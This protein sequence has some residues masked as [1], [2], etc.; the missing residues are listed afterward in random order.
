MGLK[1]TVPSLDDVQA[2]HQSLYV[3]RGDGFVLDVEG[4]D[5]H[6]EVVNLKTAY[7]RVKQD[8][9]AI[10]TER[11][12]AK[13][14]MSGL[15]ADFDAEVWNRA[16][17]GKADPAELVQLRQTLEADRDQ[18]KAKAEA[19]DKQVYE[20]TVERN[21][22]GLLATAGVTEPVFQ[23]AARVMLKPQIKVEDGKPFVDTD[24]GPL[25]LADYIPRWTSDKGKVFV[26]QPKGGGAKGGE[27][28]SKPLAE[29]GDVERLQLAQQ[30][31]L[32][33]AQ[34]AD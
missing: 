29:M 6:P 3:Q 5:S 24:M 2:E 11:D 18:W 20:L 28:G 14:K 27:G 10:R 17:A 30:G 1:V 25:A 15:P 12:D 16:K 23:E 13:A 22:D 8:R 32:K 33:A 31:K 26:S 34:A 21:L 9:D 19:G 7:D 4:V